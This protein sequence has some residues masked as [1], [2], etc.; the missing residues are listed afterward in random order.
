M[1][2]KSVLISTQCFLTDDTPTITATERGYSLIDAEEVFIN[3][4]I[5]KSLLLLIVWF[6]S[7]RKAWTYRIDIATLRDNSETRIFFPLGPLRPPS[8]SENT[9]LPTSHTSSDDIPLLEFAWL[10][11]FRGAGKLSPDN[12]HASVPRPFG[13]V[14]PSPMPHYTANLSHSATFFHRQCYH[15]LHI[16]QVSF[17]PYPALTP[18]TAHP[19]PCVPILLYNCHQ[20][21]RFAPFQHRLSFVTAKTHCD[22]RPVWILCFSITPSTYCAS[23][24][25]EPRTSLF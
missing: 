21:P 16:L 14:P 7:F 1:R 25:F 3:L 19:T 24:R 12:L 15:I 22:Y 13:P 2:K 9:A 23:R 17:P 6:G 11:W 8:L 18:H 5:K 4:F 10:A 20:V